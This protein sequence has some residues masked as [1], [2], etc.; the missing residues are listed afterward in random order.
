MND[1]LQMGPGADPV[2]WSCKWTRDGAVGYSARL[3]LPQAILS[4]TGVDTTE[5]FS[6][7][8]YL[9]SFILSCWATCL[10]ANAA[11]LYA[12]LGWNMVSFVM[13]E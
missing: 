6:H 8:V 5:V 3:H 9:E 1:T 10:A 2:L 11:I 7:G 12:E 4:N 13:D